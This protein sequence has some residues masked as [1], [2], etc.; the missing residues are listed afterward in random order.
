MVKTAI[1]GFG[2]IGRLAMRVGLLKHAGEMQFAAVNTSVSM[3]VEG[4]KHLLMQDTTYGRFEI[5]V[6][7]E[8]VKAAKEVTDADPLI[9]YLIVKSMGLKIPVL[10]QKDPEKLPWSKYGVEVVIE[11]TGKFVD[12][13]GA[14]KHA[15]AGAKRVVIS[16]P[17]KGGNVG[18][19]VIGVNASAGSAQ[20]EGGGVSNAS[21]TTN[22]VTPVAAVIHS[23]FGIM[24]AVI[25]T[26][27]AYTDEQ[28][29]QDGSHKDLHA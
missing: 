7:G 24:K 22:C 13:E 25:T 23:K 20:G 4:W 29:L 18:T 11:S 17:A 14:A 16:A 19:F 21:C 15:K 8:Q 1:N 12:E 27:H 10:A 9:G 6:E 26:V 28:V 5:E 2:R 3:E